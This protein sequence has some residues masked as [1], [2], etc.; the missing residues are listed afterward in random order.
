MGKKW[1]SQQMAFGAF[2]LFISITIRGE[3]YQTF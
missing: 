3:P 2:F 1:H